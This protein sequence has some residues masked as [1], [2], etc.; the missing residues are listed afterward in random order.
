M[1]RRAVGTI[2]GVL[3]LAM[4]GCGGLF[5][6]A[7]PSRFYVLDSAAQEAPA[8]S[9][10]A[11]GVGPVI[12]PGYAAR[13]Q[14][15]TRTGANQ[16][17]YAETDRWATPLDEGVTR[18][19]MIDLA[20]R[21]G[22]D[23]VTGFPFALGAPRDYDVSVAFLHFEPDSGGQVLVEALWRVTRASTG[24]ELAVRQ[25]SFSRPVAAGDFAAAAAALSAAIADLAGEI[26][27]E[28]RQLDAAG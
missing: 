15:A 2:A 22:T 25:A 27:A 26:A 12:L 28:L 7:P 21:L 4:A 19:L 13:Q 20:R 1:R 3:A 10:L 17:D 18:V 9:R 23:R 24:E 6:K 14:I 5:P 8:R 11:I 16:I